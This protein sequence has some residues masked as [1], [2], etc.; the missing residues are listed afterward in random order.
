MNANNDLSGKI[1]LITGGARG[2][3][4]EI[5]FEIGKRGATVIITYLKNHTAAK[6]TINELNAKGIAATRIKSNAGDETS[7]QALVKKIDEQFGRIDILVNNAASGVMRSADQLSAKHW[8]WTLD[9]NARG[10]WMLA[11]AASRLMPTGS[12]VIN[13]SS[14]GST[15]VLPSYFAVGVSKAAIEAITRYLAVELGEKG[16]SVNTVSAGF[17]MTDALNAFPDE[18]GV[19]DIALRHTP[20]GRAVT[21]SDVSK[22]VAMMCS[23]DAEMIR[24][25]IIV[26]DGGETLTHG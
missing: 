19:K 7:I 13:I 25:Q 2:I 15:R 10:P 21:A 16:I 6:T 4:K 12:R 23:G 24:G 26:V 11:V 8:N 20:A 17:V 18:L 9:I 1:A 22:V 3:G 5:A 14:P